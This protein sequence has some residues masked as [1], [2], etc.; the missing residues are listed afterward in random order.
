M[1]LART[2]ATIAGLIGLDVNNNNNA[3]VAGNLGVGTSTVNAGNVLQVIGNVNVSGTATFSN[4]IVG[5]SSATINGAAV[6][7]STTS[8]NGVT[9]FTK[10]I[11]ENKGAA[12][13]S[14]STTNIWSNADGNLLHVTGT[15]TI[16][17][18]GTAPQAGAK[19]QVIFDGV[20]TL[21]YNASTLVL[22]GGANIT[23]VAGDV[24]EF[25][26]DTTTKIIGT[27]VSIAKLPAIDGSALTGIPQ[28]AT[29]N[30]FTADQNLNKVGSVPLLL[31]NTAA[32]GVIGNAGQIN[33]VANNTSSVAKLYSQISSYMAGVTAGSENG[34]YAFSTM[35]AGV[36]DWRF[37]IGGGLFSKNATNQDKGVD[38]INVKSYYVDGVQQYADTVPWTTYAATADFG[39]TSN[40]TYQSHPQLQI[41]VTSG[42]SYEFEFYTYCTSTSAT[43]MKMQI[44]GPTCSRISG[45]HFGASNLGV[46][47]T[48]HTT[49][50]WAIDSSST[51]TNDTL[52][53]F[54]SFTPS[55]NGTV[56]IQFAQ[57]TST[58][59]TSTMHKSSRM[60]I[61]VV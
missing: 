31:Q 48:N 60:R 10:A 53:G 4:A 17:S 7:N 1:T 50:T 54:G 61:R 58:V 47:V 26:A 11:S 5:N 44:T 12:V 6:L 20:L 18:L 13:A 28:L 57:N 22:P 23:S 3:V 51:L 45:Y 8:L 29:Q 16:T 30:T 24:W 39:V 35:V 37:A 15:T 46:G 56:I 2:L 55:A 19:R 40:T 38:T 21:T 14:A 32:P 9:T 52:V 27:P 43:G 36:L 34:W 25:I 42:V 59:N 49:F 41:A 33:S